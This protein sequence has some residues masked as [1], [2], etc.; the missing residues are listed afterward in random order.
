MNRKLV[1][2]ESCV[3]VLKRIK[4]AMFARNPWCR[5]GAEIKL[6]QDC[7]SII[8]RGDWTASSCVQLAYV[9]TA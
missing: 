4:S 7:P 2:S 5:K 3:D 8:D 6:H 1:G 9:I